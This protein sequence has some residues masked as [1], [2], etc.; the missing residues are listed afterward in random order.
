MS[1]FSRAIDNIVCSLAMSRH[2]RGVAPAA[3][4]GR[5]AQDCRRLVGCS[6]RLSVDPASGR[7]VA[8]RRFGP[9]MLAKSGVTP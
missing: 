5:R 6:T 2:R 7:L 4:G 9:E 3:G 1:A 8:R